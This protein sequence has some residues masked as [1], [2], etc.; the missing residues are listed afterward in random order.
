[1]VVSLG[2]G[3]SLLPLALAPHWAAVGLGSTGILAL[4]AVRLPALQVFQMELVDTR[5]RALAYGAAVMGMGLSFGSV[6]LA[7]G[8]IIAATGY[9]SVFLIGLGLSAAGA[10][11]MI[12]IQRSSAVRRA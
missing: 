9:R 5:W 12:G 1:M 4:A 8:H 10:A 7:G 11:L 3:I 6:S 2:M